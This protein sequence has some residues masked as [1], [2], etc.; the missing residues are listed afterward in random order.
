[1]FSDMRILFSFT[2]H[3]QGRDVTNVQEPSIVENKISL[4][5]CRQYIQKMHR[6]FQIHPCAF[7][8]P[9]PRFASVLLYGW[10]AVGLLS[11]SS[12]RPAVDDTPPPMPPV[13]S[14][15]MPEPMREFRAAWIA[16]VANIDWPSAPGLSTAQ[17]QA[18]LRALLDRARLL[19]F[20]AIIL[21]VRPT[22]DAFYASDL[23]PWSEYLTGRQG[24]APNPYYDPLAFAVDEAHKR[25]LE[26]HAWFNPYR[27]LHST[28]KGPQSGTHISNTR[29][30]LVRTYGELQW[31]DPGEPVATDHSLAVILDVVRRYDIDGVHLDDYFYPYPIQDDSANDIPFPDD[32][33][34]ANVEAE[35]T[36]MSR[37]DWRRNNVDRFVERLYGAIKAAKPWVKFGISPF[38]I[39]RPGHPAQIQGFDAY[40]KLYADARK[41]QQEG[42]VDYFSPQLYWN[43][44]NPPQSYPVLLDWWAEQN[45]AG[46]H[47]W[48]GNYTSRVG[49]EDN[50]GWGAQEIADQIDVTRE[51]TE[52][53]G[54]IHFSMQAIEKNTRGIATTLAASYATPALIP[55]SPWLD[56]A[57]PAAPSL[58]LEALGNRHML[59]VE[60]EEA[61]WLWVVRTRHSGGWVMEI[62]PGW[63]HVLHLSDR[64]VREVVVSAVDRVGNE[65][66]PARVTVPPS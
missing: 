34:W 52:A 17:Q 27:A 23:E 61:A 26:L 31:I 29:P 37:D 28:A 51:R 47:L 21:Q 59:H 48:P 35:G 66:S 36:T 45:S 12:S 8:L 44:E 49:F 9:M 25:G 16:T 42:W 43:I 7:K 14:S 4:N 3:V 32:A 58:T 41:W 6:F 18:E 33:S 50:R 55:A 56:D 65:S 20:N 11:C 5:L 64:T 40:D 53:S 22:A 57:A 15:T 13:F 39:W 63:Q 54:N 24:Q 19:N 10:L 46:R 62:V 1:M 38:G 2:L 60:S 30:E